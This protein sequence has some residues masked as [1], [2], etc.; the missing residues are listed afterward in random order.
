MANLDEARR[1]LLDALFHDLPMR[2]LVEL[3]AGLVD[4]PLRFTTMEHP[5]SG[6]LSRDYPAE[7]F[8][9]WRSFVL[10]NGHVND[11]YEVFL[12]EEYGLQNY[13]RAFIFRNDPAILPRI[14]CLS[15]AGARRAGHISIPQGAVPLEE[16][17]P[18]VVLLCAQALALAYFGGSG[19]HEEQQNE[20]A[21]E[22]LLSNK[23]LTYPQLIA[24]ASSN[25]FPESGLLQLLAISLERREMRKLFPLLC[26]RI[27][28]LCRTTWVTRTD[29][30]AAVLMESKVL[31]GHVLDLIGEQL[32]ESGCRGVLSP[33][34]PRI[35]ETAA[36]HRR[37]VRIMPVAQVEGGLALMRYEDYA[38]VGLYCEAG[39]PEE[40]LI[41]FVPPKLIAISEY[42]DAHGTHYLETLSALL[43]YN[44]NQ[45]LAAAALY[46]HINTLTYR[47]RQMKDLFSLSLTEENALLHIAFGLR[48]LSYIRAKRLHRE[49]LAKV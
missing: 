21:M 13:G 36:W 5:E 46:I 18:D 45:H 37:L 3:C 25:V 6:I 39:L 41:R 15:Y 12:S 7:D 26:G 20:K 23:D 42:D 4:S 19:Q 27:S 47:L 49:R 29:T 14:L 10:E 9:N 43:R 48:L 24:V 2:D 35:M 16:I 17:D 8:Q 38:D 31:S 28:S 44:G 34:Y 22:A 30:D 11:N 33:V 1:E 32:R 40:E